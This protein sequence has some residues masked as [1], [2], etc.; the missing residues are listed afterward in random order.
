MDLAPCRACLEI[1]GW[2]ANARGIELCSNTVPKVFNKLK[3]LSAT[4]L[5]KWFKLG[6]HNSAE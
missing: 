1:L 6:V 2:P 4:E 5:K 3:A